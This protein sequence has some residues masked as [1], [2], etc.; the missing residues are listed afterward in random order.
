MC[1]RSGSNSLAVPQAAVLLPI[2][3]SSFLDL[4][5]L[6]YKHGGGAWSSLALV[7]FL[8]AIRYC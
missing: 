5:F 8:S 6:I 2:L 4:G 7:L 3:L 1:I